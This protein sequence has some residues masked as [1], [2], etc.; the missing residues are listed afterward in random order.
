MSSKVVLLIGVVA[1]GGCNDRPTGPAATAQRLSAGRAVGLP[2]TEGLASPEWQAIAR[3]FVMQSTVSRNSAAATRVYAYLSMAQ[4]DA[5]GRAED[6]IGGNESETDP[7]LGD[8]LG[9]GGRSRLE[10]DRGAV[11]GASA[12]VLTYFDPAEAQLFE[13]KVQEQANAGPGQPHP[14][15]VRGEAMGRQVGAEAIARAI[16][17]G[18][19]QPWTGTVPVGPGLW[20]SN[21][22]PPQPPVN[23][24]L[25][26]M[27]PFFLRSA[28]QFRPAP[29]PAFGSP[30]YLAALAEVRNISDTR[31]A[32]QVNIAM[33]WAKGAGTSTISGFWNVMATGWI[34]ESGLREREA[35][36][37]FALLDAA[38]MDAAIG[39]FD[40]KVTYWFIRPPQADPAIKL[41]P[42][43][44]LPNHPSYPSAHSCF[45]GA[46]VETLSAFFPA[47][48]D[49]LNAM[50]TEAGLARIY[51]G[52]HYRFDV[53]TGAQLGRNV[54]RFAGEV[55]RSGGSAVAVR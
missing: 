42:A 2:F 50:V 51:A 23:A 5:V 10:T 55:D 52:I 28:D 31:T 8:G 39:C 40:A 15:F 17:D 27:R 29:P 26:G 11:A 7:T 16:T 20:F 47:K 48:T 44:G 30:A 13:D 35:T 33:F 3:N 53:E 43:I 1:L 19:D 4:Y 32:E 41:I 24:Q 49:S 14:D 46:A 34:D 45:S 37:V 36:H 22:K 38:M 54:A 6:A 12:A 21:A 9:R 25:P 18:F